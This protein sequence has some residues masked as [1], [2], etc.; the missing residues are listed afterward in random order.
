MKNT[1]LV[2]FVSVEASSWSTRKF[3]RGG[4]GLVVSRRWFDPFNRKLSQSQQ[5]SIATASTLMK[6]M[7]LEKMIQSLLH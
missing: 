2:S 6:Q 1:P 7:D 4:D 3:V 5:F